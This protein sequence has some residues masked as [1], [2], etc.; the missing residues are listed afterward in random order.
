M[1]E[2]ALFLDPLLHSIREIRKTQ[3]CRVELNSHSFHI[4]VYN[5]IFIW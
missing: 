3:V 1:L 2:S 4:Y 5:D